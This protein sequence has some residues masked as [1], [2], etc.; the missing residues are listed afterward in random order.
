MTSFG[1]LA[2]PEY[3]SLM[4]PNNQLIGAWMPGSFIEIRKGGEQVK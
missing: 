1:K 3:G 4:S 2:D